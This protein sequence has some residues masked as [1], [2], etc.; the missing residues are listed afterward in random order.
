VFVIRGEM[1]MLNQNQYKVTAE[2]LVSKVDN[3]IKNVSKVALDKLKELRKQITSY[4]KGLKKFKPNGH[5]YCRQILL[6]ANKKL[7]RLIRN[8]GSLRTT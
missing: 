8:F 1:F 4:M 5:S 7:N 3:V 2:N 6:Q